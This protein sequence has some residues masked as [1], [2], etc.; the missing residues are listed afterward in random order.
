MAGWTDPKTQRSCAFY[1]LLG[2]LCSHIYHAGLDQWDF[3]ALLALT[4]IG[5]ASSILDLMKSRQAKEPP[6]DPPGGTV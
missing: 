6:A 3:L 1:A 2:V 4:G 5:A